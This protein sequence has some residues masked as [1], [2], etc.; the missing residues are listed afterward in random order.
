MKEHRCNR[1]VTIVSLTAL[2][3]ACLILAAAPPV[4]AHKHSKTF[5][6]GVPMRGTANGMFFDGEIRDG[7]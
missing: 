7:N 3:I 1:L 4:T 6:E 2:L 5:V